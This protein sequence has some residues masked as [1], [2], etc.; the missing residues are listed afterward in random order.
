MYHIVTSEL[1]KYQI[2]I[3]TNSS[4][5]KHTQQNFGWISK[6]LMVHGSTNSKPELNPSNIHVFFFFLFFFFT[7]RMRTALSGQP[8]RVHSPNPTRDANG[9]DQGWRFENFWLF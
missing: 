4:L 9:A 5:S 8:C 6:A 7:K 3:G 2:N 1:G